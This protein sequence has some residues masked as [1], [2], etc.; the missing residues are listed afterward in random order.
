MGLIR[1]HPVITILVFLF[2][3]IQLFPLTYDEEKTGDPISRSIMRINYYPFKTI[4]SF[5]FSIVET[6]NKYINFRDL[7]VENLRLEKENEK[8]R[9]NNFKL[10]E[11]KLQNKRLKELLKFIDDGPYE[12]ISA[13]VIAGS[14]S[15][16]RTEF[17]ILDKGKDEGIIEG[18]PVA[19]QSGIVGRVYFADKKSS[20]VMLIT[21]PISAID[22]I[23]QRTRA[24]GIIK[25]NGNNCI[26]EYIENKSD[27]D[28]GDKIISSGK[29]EFYPKGILIG[30]VEKI[31]PSG[32]LLKATVIPEVNINS[33]E[34]VLVITRLK[35]ETS[36]YE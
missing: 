7:R 8:L 33:L 17:V 9:A 27:I 23:V 16:L 35:Q 3:A 18:M 34:E 30:T 2:F 10:E 14:P 19:T 15:L 24:R 1:K 12:S 20:Q 22:A 13:N 11:I 6:W 5:K 29:D 32:G 28:P 21:D 4:S 36:L 31:E 25:G 26:L